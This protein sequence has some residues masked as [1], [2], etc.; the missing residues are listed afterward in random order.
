MG[1]FQISG[2]RVASLDDLYGV[3]FMVPQPINFSLEESAQP[4]STQPKSR[5][6]QSSSVQTSYLERVFEDSLLGWLLRS[7]F[8]RMGA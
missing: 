1:S 8:G 4:L 5:T 2:Q 7:L 3:S 6:S